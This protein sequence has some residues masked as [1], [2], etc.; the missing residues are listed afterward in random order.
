MDPSLPDVALK[1][2]PSSQLFMQTESGL[3]FKIHLSVYP[4]GGVGQR[5]GSQPPASLSFPHDP[6]HP[7]HERGNHTK[8]RWRKPWPPEALSPGTPKP[9]SSPSP[10]SAF[11]A[12]QRCRTPNCDLG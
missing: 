4:I 9:L 6:L 8:W 11:I 1:V 12:R 5:G 3:C 10:S 2:M 7:P